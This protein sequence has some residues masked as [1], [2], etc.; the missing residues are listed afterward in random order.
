MTEIQ[1]ATIT[2]VPRPAVPIGQA[3][4]QMVG[5]AE[6]ALSRL[7]AGILAETGTPRETYLALQRMA[8]LG[9]GP[10]RA[11]YA[12][13][14]NDAFGLDLWAAGNL[15]DTLVSAGLLAAGEGGDDTVR[16]TPAGAE[17]R[18]KLQDSVRAVNAPLWESLDVVALDTTIKTLREITARARALCPV[19]RA[20]EDGEG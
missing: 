6:T 17:L 5:Q 16:L 13:D 8:A 18:S 4:G 11:D 2:T 12:R 10:L 7:L 1:H 15:V 3:I 19:G 14:L 9:D 20:S